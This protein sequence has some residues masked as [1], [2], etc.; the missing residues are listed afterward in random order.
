MFTVELYAAII[1][2]LST[3]CTRGPTAV[4]CATQ[5]SFTGQPSVSY[6]PNRQLT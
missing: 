2:E 6:K 3:A 5:S 1:A 4:G